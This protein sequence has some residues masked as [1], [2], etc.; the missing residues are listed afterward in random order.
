MKNAIWAVTLRYRDNT[1]T[2]VVW[3]TRAEAQQQFNRV[4]LAPGSQRSV[5]PIPLSELPDYI[6]RVKLR[7]PATV[8]VCL[9]GC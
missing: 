4:M 6:A 8:C 9:D 2:I 1:A 7:H 5:N 3:R